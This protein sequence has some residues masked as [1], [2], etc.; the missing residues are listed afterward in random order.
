[1]LFK[2]PSSGGF[3]RKTILFSAFENPYNKICKT[4]KLESIHE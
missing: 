2:V 3:E 1:M 4:R